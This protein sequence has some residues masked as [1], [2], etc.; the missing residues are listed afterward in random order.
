MF[1]VLNNFR[2]GTSS[3]NI[4]CRLCKSA[5][6]DQQHLLQCEVLKNSIPELQSNKTVKYEHIF[7]NETQKVN[8]AKLLYKIVQERENLL[9]ALSIAFN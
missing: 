3:E 7:G 2:N 6:E 9:H 8:A 5:L 1:P 4:D